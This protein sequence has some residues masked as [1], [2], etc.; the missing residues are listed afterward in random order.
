MSFEDDCKRLIH[1]SAP[2]IFEDKFVRFYL[3]LIFNEDPGLFNH[4]WLNEVAGNP[5]ARV[6]VVDGK[7]N[8]ALFSVPPIRNSPLADTNSVVS[9]TLGYIQ[10]EI[11]AKSVYGYALLEKTLPKLIKFTVDRDN[12]HVKEWQAILDRYGYQEVYE[13]EASADI[14]D[15]NFYSEDIDGW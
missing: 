4:R 6:Y 15:Q 1:G 10:L 5:H 3:P 11:Q 12:E 13:K 8:K 7:T 2:T 14:K 9:Q